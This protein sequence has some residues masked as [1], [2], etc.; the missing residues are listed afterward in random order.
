MKKSFLLLPLLM[1][2]V[3][4]ADA[5]ATTPKVDPAACGALVEYHEAPGVEYQPGV[6]VNGNKVAPAD[7][8]SG[9]AQLQLPKK[10]TIPLT[11][12]LASALHLTTSA[13]PGNQ[14][15]AGTEMQI[16][17]ITIEDGKASLNG[18]PLSDPQQDKLATL[19]A[20]QKSSITGP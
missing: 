5:S 7:L 12:S 3:A 15:G 4:L 6:D 14:F 19:C 20:G 17:T 10:I 16:G 2:C 13:Y 18:Q 11:I 9:A 8:P 1:P